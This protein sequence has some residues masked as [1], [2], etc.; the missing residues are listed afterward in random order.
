MLS[1]ATTTRAIADIRVGKRFRRDLGNLAALAQSIRGFERVLEPI[2]ITPENELVFGERRLKA[3]Q[4]AGHTEVLVTV[5]DGD[6]ALEA[7]GAE[8]EYRKPYAPSEMVEYA[9]FL[10]PIERE[11]ARQRQGQRTDL[12][13]G[14]FPRSE[15][16]RAQDRVGRAVGADRKT[17]AKARA[18]VRAAESEP[19]FQPL[20]EAMD[21]TGKVE[22]PYAEL[23]RIQIEDREAIPNTGGVQAKIITGDFRERGHIVEDNST[24]LVF[25]DAPYRRKD[26]PIYGDL[27]KFAAR[28]LIPGGSL[29]CYAPNFALPEVLALL[30]PHLRYWFELACLHTGA[31]RVMRAFGVHVGWKPML[32]FVKQRRRT[33]MIVS[34]NVKCEPGNK[35]TGHEW[36]QGTIA[37]SYYIEKLTRRGSLVVDPFLGSGTTAVAA[38]K[39]ERRFVGFEINADTAA[40]AEARI[41]RGT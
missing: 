4:M 30:Q 19:R 41:L 36:A 9:D 22:G 34:D 2:G 40:K 31:N 18:V 13:P 20:R 26:L 29:I 6:K 38:I 33:R 14:K 12:L 25:A 17:L 37:A 15:S 23:L 11:K 16:G 27:G 10:E 35:I 1:P 21:R 8:N 24:D 28:V 32:W 3:A 7:Q 39:L 5:I